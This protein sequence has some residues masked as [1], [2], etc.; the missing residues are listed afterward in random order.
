MKHHKPVGVLIISVKYAASAEAKKSDKSASKIEEETKDEPISGILFSTDQDSYDQYSPNEDSSKDGSDPE[1]DENSKHSPAMDTRS[2]VIDTKS[3]VDLQF[4]SKSH[5]ILYYDSETKTH[6]DVSVQTQLKHPDKITSTR[7][8]DD[9]YLL[10]GGIDCDTGEYTNIV[11]HY[12]NQEYHPR[13]EINVPRACHTTFYYKGYV[14]CFGGYN[15]KGVLKSIEAHDMNS[16]C[17]IEL[18]DMLTARYDMQSYLEDEYIY[19]V[20]GK[21]K[22]G[23]SVSTIERFNIKTNGT[24]I[25]TK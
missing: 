7:L 17:W 20:G 1:A 6:I 21:T 12:I 3:A 5:E 11:A 24:E 25:V 19:L 8:P 22:D 4:K 18:P 15:Q 10:T 14:Y 16:N 9:S 13:A 23:K 2:S